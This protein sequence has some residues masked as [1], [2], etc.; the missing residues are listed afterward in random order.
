[1]LF[2]CAFDYLVS[3]NTFIWPILFKIIC[4][5]PKHVLDVLD[6]PIFFINGM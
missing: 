3:N 5:A 1:M 4:S 6:V 2:N